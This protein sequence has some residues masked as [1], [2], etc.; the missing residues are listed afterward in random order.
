MQ[1]P[2][3][4]TPPPLP[5]PTSFRSQA[6]YAQESL[7]P[8]QPTTKASPLPAP[9]QD[10]PITKPEPASPV[11]SMPNHPPPVEPV[12]PAAPKVLVSVG[13]QTEYDPF[14]PS[15]QAGIPVSH[16]PSVCHSPTKCLF[17]NLSSLR[18]MF[19]LH[20]CETVNHN[21]LRLF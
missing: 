8:P 14:F 6:S 10:L 11:V 18:L 17:L 21:C 16:P 3:V 12:Q 2:S 15:M 1:Q 4:P 9:I 5:P 19:H 7:P 13:C 20:L